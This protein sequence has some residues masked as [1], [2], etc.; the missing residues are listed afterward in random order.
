MYAAVESSKARPV[1]S[2]PILHRI[3]LKTEDHIP[4]PESAAQSL[5]FKPGAG[6]G[7]LASRK[8]EARLSLAL[9]AVGMGTWEWN[10]P[11]NHMEWDPR[12]H[13]LFGLGPGEFGGRYEDFLAL[14]HRET[15][16]GWRGRSISP[17][18]PTRA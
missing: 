9:K 14:V 4:P 5:D 7:S 11:D 10:V 18:R 13:H 15:G 12:M 3:R 8:N 2:L 6:P 1:R 16:S 17:V